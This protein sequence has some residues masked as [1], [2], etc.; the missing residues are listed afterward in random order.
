M[1]VILGCMYQ[2]PVSE[3]EVELY[4]YIIKLGQFFHQDQVTL[5]RHCRQ[6]A[7]PHT[8]LCFLMS[9]GRRYGWH[10]TA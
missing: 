8:H 7:V 4:K 6:K 1:E 3:N 5:C 9:P 2:D 10:P